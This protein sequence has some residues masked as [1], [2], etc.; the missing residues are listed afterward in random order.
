MSQTV[1]QEKSPEIKLLT[2]EGLPF[3]LSKLL[4]RNVLIVLSR[5]FT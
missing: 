4:G 5:G 1:L 3:E 2:S